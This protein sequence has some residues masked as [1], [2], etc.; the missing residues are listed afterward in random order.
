MNYDRIILELM[1]RVSTLEDEVKNLKAQVITETD[2]SQ[3]IMEQGE[4]GIVLGRSK[5][6]VGRD[7]TKFILDGKRY[8]KNR[9]VL[10][11]IKKYV[12][13]NPGISAERLLLTFDKSLQGS[14]GVVR[15]L[16]DVKENCSDYKKRFFTASDEVIHTSSKDCVVCN[17]WGI[18]NIGNMVIRAKQLGIQVQEIK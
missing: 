13:M 2:S 6:S 1:D 4:E 14:L 12:A 3:G 18:A 5:D 7:T 8:V 10:A 17:Q 16:E 15:T 9:L 11:I